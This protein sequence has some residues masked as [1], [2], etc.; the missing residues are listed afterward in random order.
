MTVKFITRK[1]DKINYIE[2]NIL[3][4]I[5]SIN[6]PIIQDAFNDEHDRIMVHGPIHRSQKTIDNPEKYYW[7]RISITDKNNNIIPGYGGIHI[8][9]CFQLWYWN[10]NNYILGECITP[11]P[12]LNQDI[13]NVENLLGFWRFIRFTYEAKKSFEQVVRSID[14]RSQITRKRNPFAIINPKTGEKITI[15]D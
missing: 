6:E 8:F 11:E 4:I 5:R 14:T 15:D 13:A 10:N 1:Y 9:L 3:D 7:L 2:Q 12:Y